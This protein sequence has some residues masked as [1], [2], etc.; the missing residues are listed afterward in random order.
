MLNI[1]RS[2]ATC[3]G[4]NPT[5]S[6]VLIRCPDGTEVRLQVVRVRN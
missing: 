6:A 3:N 5:E 1:T 2:P 4:R